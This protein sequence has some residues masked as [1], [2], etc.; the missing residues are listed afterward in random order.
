MQ[1]K[2]LHNGIKLLKH[3][4]FLEATNNFEEYIIYDNSD[5]LGYY[6]LGL[7]YIFRELYDEAYKYITKANKLNEN[8]LSTINTL[9][10]LNLKFDNVD[11]AINYWLDILDIDKKNY[12][13]KRNLDKVKK[14]KHIQKLVTSAEPDE[15]INFKIKKGLHLSNIM[16]ILPKP[17]KNIRPLYIWISLGI[18]TLS[19]LTVF[20]IIKKPFTYKRTP[21]IISKATLYKVVLP[22]MEA[23]YIIDKKSIY[24]YETNFNFITF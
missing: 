4:D 5:Y 15:F 9:A 14:S 7:A 2:Y 16:P 20:I 18:I 8:D 23:D 11:E 17:L 6:Y 3:G 21:K 12:I 19:G 13:A 24:K 1:D 22:N 10:F